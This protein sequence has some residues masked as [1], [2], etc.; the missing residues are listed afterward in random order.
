MLIVKARV[1][2]LIPLLLPFLHFALKSNGD[3]VN[4]VLKKLRCFINTFL[5]GSRE[6]QE[7]KNRV[8]TVVN[9]KM[10]VTASYIL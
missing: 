7:H 9:N 10:K 2:R 5:K 4:L 6:I 8:R 3:F 1:A